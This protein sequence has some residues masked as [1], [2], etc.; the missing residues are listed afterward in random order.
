LFGYC[1]YVVFSVVLYYPRAFSHE[2]ARKGT[3]FFSITQIFF[4][5]NVFFFVFFG[6][7]SLWF[8]FDY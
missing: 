6:K 3:A 1:F 4:N 2:I 5:K 8:P 7:N